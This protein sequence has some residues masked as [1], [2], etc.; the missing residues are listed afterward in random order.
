MP[1]L[2]FILGVRLHLFLRH[3]HTINLQATISLLRNLLEVV[4]EVQQARLEI[5]NLICTT[6]HPPSGNSEYLIW[7]S[8]M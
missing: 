6:F 4:E 7:F 2:F 5:K 8:L 3:D 1:C